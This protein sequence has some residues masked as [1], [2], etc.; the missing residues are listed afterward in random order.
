MNALPV[1]SAAILAG[2]FAGCSRPGVSTPATAPALPPVKARVVAIRTE[3]TPVTT[4]I[5]GTVRPVER[6]QLAAKVMGTIEELPVTLGQRVKR[7]DVL[8][9]IGAAE[10]TARVAQAK[11]QLNAAARDLDR[12]RSLL[13]KGASTGDMVKGL[14]DRQAGAAAMLREAEAMLGYATLRA[15]F[16]GVVARKLAH[17]GDLASPGAPLLEIEGAAGFEVEAGVPDSLAATLAVGASL[18]VELPAAGVSLT[19]RI[20]EVSSAAD[21]GARTVTIKIML[22]EHPAARSGQFAR[23]QVP[24][25][26]VPMLLAPA[27]AVSTAGQMERVFVSSRDNR[28]VLRLVKTGAR[29]GDRV[30]IL[31]GLDDGE[32]VVMNPPAGLREGQPL[33]FQP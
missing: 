18:A 2:L 5:T 13:G 32:R 31:S 4:E 12:E 20:A 14:E 33:E 19:G 26:A 23:I 29:H 30:E 16:D 25:A 28:A 8:V 1:F 6:A 22:P 3:S 21:P 17:A 24:G 10:I 27:A 7:G 11:S 9:K 15:P